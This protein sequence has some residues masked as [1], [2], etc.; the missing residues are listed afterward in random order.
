MCSVFF[1]HFIHYFCLISGMACSSST[2]VL[3]GTIS[4]F[5]DTWETYCMQVIL[6]THH[7][8]YVLGFAHFCSKSSHL[9]KIKQC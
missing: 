8:D 9:F 3:S 1:L 6:V 4:M 2:V 5:D 7:F